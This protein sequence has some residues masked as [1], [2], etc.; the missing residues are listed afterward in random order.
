MNENFYS[1]SRWSPPRRW[2]S[3]PLWVCTIGVV[4]VFL[5]IYCG[6]SV[7]KHLRN[8]GEVYH[9]GEEL[10]PTR[11]ALAF[12]VLSPFSA[13]VVFAFLAMLCANARWYLYQLCNFKKSTYKF[14]NNDYTR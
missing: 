12:Y 7:V 13:A 2:D 11:M 8:I 14:R 3:P 4:I 9:L 5:D 10:L 6:L 1:E